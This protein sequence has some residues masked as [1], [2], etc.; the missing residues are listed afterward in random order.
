L[1]E[2]LSV[3]CNTATLQHGHTSVK[4]QYLQ[5]AIQRAGIA[6]SVWL[7][8]S[9]TIGVRLPVEAGNF[10]LLHRVQTGSGDHPASYPM[11]STGGYFPGGKAAGTWSWP[12]TS[13]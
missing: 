4:L 10:S 7:A 1:S 6:Q 8:T 5:L 12:L 3:V 2:M 13:I 11:G 9:W